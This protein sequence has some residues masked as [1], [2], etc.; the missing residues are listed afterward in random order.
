M[1]WSLKIGPLAPVAA[2]VFSPD[3]K[4]LAAGSYGQV[5][6]WDVKAG[7]LARLL[8]NVLGAVNDLKFSPDG[9]LLAVAGGQPSAKGD[10]RFY[11]TE[12]WKLVGVLRG[13]DDVV[14]SVAFRKDGKQLASASFD[15]NVTLWDVAEKKAIK[16]FHNHSDFVYAVAFDPSGN[17]LYSASKDKT[18]QMIDVATGKSKFTFSGGDQDILAVA[19]SPDGKTLLSAGFDAGILVWNPA[20]GEKVKTAAGHTNG[21]HEIVFSTKGNL[22][23]SGGA[24]KTARVWD[25]AA[26]TPVKAFSVGSSVYAVGFSPDAKLLATGSADGITRLWDASA[27]TA[28]VSLVAL[29]GEK[30]HPQWAAVTPQGF[31]TGDEQFLKLG[32]F[33]S[34]AGQELADKVLR[35][36]L[37]NAGLVAAAFRGEAVPE[38]SFGKK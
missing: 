16:T 21:T 7:K 13:H 8:T 9:S 1:S 34:A 6:V 2:V 33:R 25:A 18:V 17:Y 31:L 38:A 3:G 24:D 10:L 36:A 11:Q 23:A 27:G 12:G 15:H 32:R 14:F 35:P 30:D 29:P 20:T 19:I 26:G 22:Y 4:Y 37:V 28:L 5:A